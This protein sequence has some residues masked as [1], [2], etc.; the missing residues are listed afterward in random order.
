M[1]DFVCISLS[2]HL[3]PWPLIAKRV[4]MAAQGDFVIVLYNPKSGRRTRQIVETQRI[5]LRYRRPD[6]PVGLVKSAYRARQRVTLTTLGKMLDEEIG[7]LTTVIIG[8]S[9]TFVH[10]G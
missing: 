5:L 7:M 2:D 1:H 10:E 4:E 3:T 6:T 8:N 9:T